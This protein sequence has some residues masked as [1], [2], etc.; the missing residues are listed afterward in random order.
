MSVGPDVR[1]NPSTEKDSVESLQSLGGF[2]ERNK[3]LGITIRVSSVLSLLRVQFSGVDWE[4][5]VQKMRN[6]S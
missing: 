6:M 2:Y 5:M 4:C 3:E 1:Q